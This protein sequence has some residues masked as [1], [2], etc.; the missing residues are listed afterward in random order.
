MSYRITMDGSP[1]CSSE[2]EHSSLLDPVVSLEV[3]KAGSLTFT[4]MPDHPMYDQVA[5][6]QSMFDVY[7]NEEL[8]FEGIAVSEEVD[9]YNRKTVVCEGELTFLN[10]TIQRQAKY[11]NMSVQSLLAAY[12]TVHNAQADNDRKFSLGSVTVDGGNGILRYTNF[13]STMK[14]I[15]EDLVDN[16]GGY[17][18]VRHQGGYRYLDYLAEPPRTSSQVIRIWKNLIDLSSNLSSLDIV[19]ILI[20][21]GAKI[22]G[23]EDVEG[24]EKRLDIKSVNGGLDYLIGTA[25]SWYGSIWGT[26]TWD[27]VTTASALKTK[28]QEYLEEAQWSN[29]VISASAFDLGLMDEDVEQ[30]RLLDMIRVVSEPHG[31]DKLFLLSQLEINLDHPADT[32]ITLGKD[33]RLSLSARSAKNTTEIQNVPTRILPNASEAA[34]QILDSS[35]DGNIYF[36]F[37]EDTGKL[38]EIDILDTNNPETAQRIWRWNLGGWGYSSDGGQT[39][40]VAAT[41]DGALVASL[42]TTGILKSDDGT[43]FYLDLD[44]GILKGNFTELKIS[45]SAGATQSYADSAASSAVSTYDGNL[46]QL[47]VFNKLTNNG[48]TQG[49]YLQNNKVYINGEYIKANTIGADSIIGDSITIAKLAPTAKDVLIT[50]TTVK[51]QYYLSTSSSSATGGSWSDTTPTWSS[52]KYVW[53]RVSTT[54]TYADGD[55]TT[56]TSTAVYDKTLTDALST[57]A[58]ASS[59]ASSAQTTANGNV[60]ST[61]SCYYRSTSSTTPTISTSTSIGTSATTDNAWEYVMPRPKKNTYMFTCERYTKA[62]GSVSFST[63][64]QMSML[65]YASMWCS[66]NDA[67]CIDGG[68]IYANSVTAN[69]I[70]VNNLFSQNITATNFH[71]TNGSINIT[72]N[73]QTYDYIQLNHTKSSAY[74]ASN[75]VAV[76]NKSTADNPYLR[77]S[78]QGGGVFL[79]NTNTGKS[80]ASLV[81]T[82][83]TGELS[84]RDSAGT[85]RTEINNS[86]AAFFNSSGTQQSVYYNDHAYI[87]NASGASII[88]LNATTAGN[89]ELSLRDGTRNRAL[90]N[91]GGLY[92]YNSSGTALSN[93]LT[94][95]IYIRNSSGKRTAS[96]VNTTGGNGSLYLADSNETNRAILNDGGLYFYDSGGTQRLRINSASSGSITITPTVVSTW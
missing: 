56:T 65:T 2:V 55:S 69:Q 24:L 9:F 53:T 66:A 70:D 72:T 74:M 82:G 75:M 23:E 16:Y 37:D 3:N 38:Y 14:E 18:R 64:R 67:T 34:R 13:Q 15:G 47:A 20:P 36:R 19:T 96:I 4:M 63:V 68:A 12:L 95:S 92:F 5:L 33:T 25:Q 35:T 80:L 54:K 44:N 41:M 22:E 10:D 30:F 83:G 86:G 90:L 7:Q 28:G 31:I 71:I 46:N 91:D 51:N 11:T 93:Y 1:F 81:S 6:R 76:E 42:I 21:L 73:N 77:T 29:L 88:Y 49:I 61:V 87:R 43:T 89:G 85:V 78:L 48:V 40:T 84:L 17:L 45:G 60:T 39:Y 59:A 26:Q 58:S 62:D 27:G 79:S 50:G 32:Q 57:A 94:S 8:I 52:G